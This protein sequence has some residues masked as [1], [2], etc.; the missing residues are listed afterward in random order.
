MPKLMHMKKLA[1]L[2]ELVQV[3]R[4]L[5]LRIFKLHLGKSSVT[6]ALFRMIEPADG[7]IVI[8][9]VNISNLGLHDLRSNLTII[10][11]DPVLF[12][13]SLRFNLDPFNRYCDNEIWSALEHANLKEFAYSHPGKLEHE[14]TEG[15]ANI[16]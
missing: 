6:L 1:L 15:G 9:G 11:Q 5:S 4:F 12:S 7:K 2:A 16:R 13:G 10:P 3:E 14:I 8:D